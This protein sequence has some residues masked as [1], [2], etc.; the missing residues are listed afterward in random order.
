MANPETAAV[1][2]TTP[3]NTTTTPSREATGTGE[4]NRNN[5]ESRRPRQYS[6]NRRVAESNE[7]KVETAKMNGNVFQVHSERKNKS[8]FSDT[9]D[10]L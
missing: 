1:A 9:V 6:Y 2:D 7:F 3:I 10:A 5:Q 4:S 8:Q